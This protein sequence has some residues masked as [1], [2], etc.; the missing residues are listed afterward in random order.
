MKS[1]NPPIPHYVG[2]ALLFVLAS[3]Y[4]VRAVMYAFPNYFGRTDAAYPFVPEYE[5]G[6]TF[7]K[8]TN[9]SARQ[10]GTNGYAASVRPK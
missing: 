6:R 4:H 1:K 5:K 2:L 3:A 9:R 10:A 8:F 7:L